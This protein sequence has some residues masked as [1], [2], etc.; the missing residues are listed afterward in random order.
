M[1]YRSAQRANQIYLALEDQMR[2]RWKLS[3]WLVR[4]ASVSNRDSERGIANVKIFMRSRSRQDMRM[5][6]L[7]CR[8]STSLRTLQRHGIV[9]PRARLGINTEA[10]SCPLMQA[11]SRA[12]SRQM[13]EATAILKDIYHANGCIKST[14]S[15]QHYYRCQRAMSSRC[16]AQ[17]GPGPR[18]SLCR[19]TSST[20]PGSR[21]V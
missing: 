5:R 1:V 4:R 11:T 21:E 8:S 13:L 14:S 17:V 10:H 19:H 3:A 18:S 6:V 12:Y 20:R 16:S 7:L 2:G 15:A 9:W